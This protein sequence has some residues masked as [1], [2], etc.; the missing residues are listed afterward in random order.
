L[1]V[2]DVTHVINYSIP[3]ELDN[4]VHRIGRTARSGKDGMAISLVT[5]SHK[6]LLGQIERLTKSRITEIPVPTRKSLGLKKVTQA[7]TKLAAQTNF[8]RAV[9]LMDEDSKAALAAMPVEEV[10][11]R[12]LMIMHPEI[13]AEQIPQQMARPEYN[14]PA[15]GPRNYDRRP[16]RPSYGDRPE[17]AERPER[18]DRHD[19]SERPA[20]RGDFRPA[21]RAREDF[22]PARAA[23]S[24]WDDAG[25]AARPEQK[26]EG[27]RE[28]RPAAYKPFKPAFKRYTKRSGDEASER[29]SKPYRSPRS[30]RN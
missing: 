19:R 23:Q 16:A 15:E 14:G 21:P 8:N 26:G 25:P 3:R 9:E 30:D 7:L 24:S 10:A 22:R 1:D 5:P 4:Y 28:S 29:P 13:F 18:S 17:R 11:A 20:P 6:Y 27:S 12:F 2:K